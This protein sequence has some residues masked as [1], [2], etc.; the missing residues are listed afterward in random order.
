M[1]DYTEY[2]ARL[3]ERHSTLSRVGSEEAK[4]ADAHEPQVARRGPYYAIH[5]LPRAVQELRS[6]RGRARESQIRE[7]LAK[8]PYLDILLDTPLGVGATLSESLSTSQH[9]V[10]LGQP[11]AGKSTALK[12]LAAHPLSVGQTELLTLIVDLTEFSPESQDL[13]EFLAEDAVSLGLELTPSFFAHALENGQAILCLD[14]LD[15]I[16]QQEDRARTV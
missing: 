3:A 4:L 7:Q 8:Q 10:L 2:A 15:Q 13:T 6:A 9:A 12:Y 14:G 16:T 11:G 1:S 5:E